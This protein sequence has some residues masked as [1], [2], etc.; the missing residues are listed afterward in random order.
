MAVAHDALQGAA[1][2]PGEFNHMIPG[3]RPYILSVSYG[4]S[5]DRCPIMLLRYNKIFIYR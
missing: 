2:W 1:T 4:D 5:Y 3:H